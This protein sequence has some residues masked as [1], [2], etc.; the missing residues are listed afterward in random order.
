MEPAVG[1]DDLCRGL[2]VLVVAQHDTAAPDADLAGL[3]HLI[4]HIV[5][6]LMVVG[7]A[8]GAH[9]VGRL[10]EVQ[11][12]VAEGLGHAVALVDDEA[13]LGQLQQHLGVEGR[14]GAA[15]VPQAVE[16]ADAAPLEV[17]V[18][19]LHQHGGRGHN[20]AVHQAEVAVEVADVAAEVQC[21]AGGR[22]GHDA[23]EAGHVEEGQ[24]G[25][26]AQRQLLALRQTGRDPVLGPGTVGAE[27]GA[28]IP[29]REHDALAAAG[30]AGGEHQHHQVIV[31]DAVGQLTG[32]GV[33]IAVHRTELR[34]IGGFQLGTAA[35]VDAVVQDEGRFHKTQ[36]IFQLLPHLFLVEGHEDAPCKDDAE[37][38]HTVLVAVPAQQHNTLALDAGH[39]CLEVGSHPA[40]VLR[41]LTVLFFHDGLAVGGHIADSHIVGEFLLH[42]AGHHIIYA[43]GDFDLF[44]HWSYS[45]FVRKKSKQHHFVPDSPHFWQTEEI[46]GSIPLGNSIPHM[47]RKRK[48]SLHKYAI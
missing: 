44:S 35:V 26:V 31:A 33:P 19:R 29:L 47:R 13:V 46:S 32:G 25:H 28:H 15:Q 24:Q 20:V 42:A 1:V 2:G 12:A 21:P 40:D 43:C 37:G 45:F 5:V 39:F 4:L 30:G 18:N 8:H 11:D 17:V 23:D 16:A 36:L 22:V 14:R 6:G 10:G 34:T 3:V 9:V 7:L 41:V 27:A 48:I 38:C